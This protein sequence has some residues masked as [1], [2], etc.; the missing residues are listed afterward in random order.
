MGASRTQGQAVALFFTAFVFIAGS[1]AADLNWLWM[2]VG[3]VIGALAVALFLKCKPLE[4]RE[5]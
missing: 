1:F 2:I 4:H 3:L 5:E